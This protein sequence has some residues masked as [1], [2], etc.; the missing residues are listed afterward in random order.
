MKKPQSCWTWPGLVCLAL[1]PSF[2]TMVFLMQVYLATSVLCP[3]NHLFWERVQ[4]N[5][6]LR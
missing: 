3:Q 5:D 4:Q 2:G 1:C 6:S